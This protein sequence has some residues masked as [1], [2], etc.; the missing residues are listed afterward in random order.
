MGKIYIFV[1]LNI[2]YNGMDSAYE[3]REQNLPVRIPER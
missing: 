3:K 2:H 1:V